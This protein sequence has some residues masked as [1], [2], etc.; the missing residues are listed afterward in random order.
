MRNYMRKIRKNKGFTIIEMLLALTITALLLTAL[1]A[2]IN[3]SMVN[4]NA[5]EGSYK[6]V[7]NARQ[8]LSR[9]CAELRTS[10]G[11]QV[12]EGIDFCTFVNA[13]GDVV[14][15]WHQNNNRT[16]YLIKDSTLYVLCRNVDDLQ[17]TKGV[18]PENPGNVRNVQI[19]MT[20]SSG[21]VTK[22][23]ST[24]AVIMRNMP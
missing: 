13:D 17:F 15:Y 8:A 20:V 24:A 12:F 21:G 6:T 5:N 7:N 14:R 23:L 4:L 19:T 18:D 22:K 10:S 9:M 2:S 16:L 3:A 11:V 1:A